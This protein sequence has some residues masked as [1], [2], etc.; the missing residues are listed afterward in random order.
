[1]N[2]EIIYNT[3]ETNKTLKE[4]YNPEGSL[5]RKVQ[6][7]M[8]EMLIYI[9][10]VCKHLDI[11]YILDGGTV[12]GAVRHGGFIP[13][14][15]DTDIAIPR[16]YFKQLNEYLE[17][18]PHP[19]FVLQNNKTDKGYMGAWAVLRDTKSEYIQNSNI[20][21]I[22][23]YRGVQVDI[24]PVEEIYSPRVHRRMASLYHFLINRMINKGHIRIAHIGYEFC[25]KVFFP[26]LRFRSKFNSENV[27]MY[28]LG[29]PWTT[30]FDKNLFQER[31][32]IKFE[33]YSFYAPKDVD[34]YL[35]LLYGDYLKLP[36]INQRNHHKAT[37][38]I[39]D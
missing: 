39:F 3:G 12:L 7:R 14:D 32:I 33:G 4:N 20:H 16:K 2:K 15:D 30:I 24:F 5:L 13:W 10:G 21:N 9:D 28:S 38:K 1:M 27:L 34:K 36:P 11:P 31:G 6:L 25:H 26:L 29:A 17:K 18:N 8:L 37:Y 35:K 19:Q 23:K 22:R